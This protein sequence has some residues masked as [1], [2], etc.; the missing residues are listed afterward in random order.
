L[1]ALVIALAAVGALVAWRRRTVEMPVG[2]AVAGV[3]AFFAVDEAISIHERLGGRVAALFGLS[4]SW[5]SV[6][7]PALYVP[8]A[9]F[10]L[11]LMSW[12]STRAPAMNAACLRGAALL[13]VMAVA[14]EVVSA[15][16]STAETADGI[17]HQIEGAF[18]ES[19][20]L[21]AWSLTAIAFLRWHPQR[22][23]SPQH[24]RPV[25]RVSSTALDR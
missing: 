15:P 17:V 22:W 12:C 4:Q 23:P 9:G 11:G 7:W 6:V 13:L 24:V 21:L 2:L 20:E 14:L 3:L 8:L 16:F 19:F 5:D 25:V 10:V 18:E 1:Q